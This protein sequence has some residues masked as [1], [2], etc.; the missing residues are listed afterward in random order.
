MQSSLCCVVLMV[1][2]LVK[3]RSSQS[4]VYITMEKHW[5]KLAFL[6]LQIPQSGWDKLFISFIPADSGK[7]IAKTTKAAVRNGTCKWGDPIYETTR[8]LQDVKSK[9]F[10]EKLY[11]LVVAMVEFC[12]LLASTLLYFKLVFLYY[13]SGLIF[14]FDA[15]NSFLIESDNTLRVLHGLVSW[16]RQQLIL[17]I[18]LKHQSLLLLLCLF[19]DAMREQYYMWGKYCYSW[20]F[21]LTTFSICLDVVF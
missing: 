11:K 9:Q 20:H 13:L 12:F 5:L 19:K 14:L 2:D 8:L 4:P 6:V 21:Y 3:T 18:M 10:D 1:M 16:A 7:T 17:L 15:F